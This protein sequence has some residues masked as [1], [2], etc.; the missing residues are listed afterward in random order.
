MS[1]LGTVQR[2]HGVEFVCQL[3]EGDL[4]LQR[5]AI[6]TPSCPYYAVHHGILND[7]CD[8]ANIKYNHL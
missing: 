6:G 8:V 1:E 3:G 2:G 7:W 5:V 4:T